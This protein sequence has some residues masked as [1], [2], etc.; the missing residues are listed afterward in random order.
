MGREFSECRQPIRA[1]IVEI[2]NLF[3]DSIGISDF[4]PAIQ[5]NL[6]CWIQFPRNIR[7]LAE[8]HHEIASELL[9]RQVL[10]RPDRVEW[11]GDDRIPPVV[12][13]CREPTKAGENHPSGRKETP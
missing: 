5:R 8:R 6:C 10:N 11:L 7:P 2:E 12:P 13:Y 1:A 9:F 3:N 4:V